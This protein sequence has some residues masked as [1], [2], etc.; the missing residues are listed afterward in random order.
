MA[1]KYLMFSM[2]DEKIESLA[3]V[4]S[5]KTC[6][7][8]LEFLAETKEA[9][10]QDIAKSLGMPLNTVEYN[11]KTLLEV[12]LIEKTKN[13]FWSQKG[14]KIPT[15]KVSNKSI[16]ISPKHDFS[17]L[18]A[19]LPTAIISIIGAFVLRQIISSKEAVNV[20][21]QK[22]SDAFMAA[23]SAVG[24]SGVASSAAETLRITSQRSIDLIP[25]TDVWAW[26]LLGTLFA[27]FLFIILN[28]RRM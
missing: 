13:F 4:L 8:I 15:Y 5:N 14:K 21:A 2:E 25:V 11:L 16:I 26:F 7:K 10:E 12:K 23:P 9:S 6:K 22:S 24:S 17:K 3:K 18:K 1:E 20:V 28:W 27:V 19:F